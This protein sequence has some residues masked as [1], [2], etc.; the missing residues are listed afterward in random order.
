MK[1]ISETVG[2]AEALNRLQ[3]ISSAINNRN[4][5]DEFHFFGL[6]VASQLRQLPLYEALGVQ[7]EI[8]A[9][10][11]AARR[12]NMYPNLS[13]LPNTST[14]TYNNSPSNIQLITSTISASNTLTNILQSSNSHILSCSNIQ[15]AGICA[16]NYSTLSPS[17][18]QNDADTRNA[19]SQQDHSQIN[20]L[21]EAWKLS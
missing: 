21:N 7:N 13:V 14:Q 9:I 12:R 19:Q 6:N 10:L 2:V 8:Q 4:A 11:T 15:P 18:I 20:L 3:N 16:S 5:E 1:K 17:N